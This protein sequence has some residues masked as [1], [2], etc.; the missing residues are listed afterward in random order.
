QSGIPATVFHRDLDDFSCIKLVVYLTDVG[1]DDGPHQFIPYSHRVES[2]NQYLRSTGKKADLPSL[3]R[4]NSKTL[5]SAELQELFN[6]DIVTLTGPAGFG[7]LEDPY[8]L[9]R[10]SRPRATTRLVFSCMYTGLAL[11]FADKNIRNQTGRTVS[12]SEVGLDN[13]S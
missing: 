12:F 10:E 11:P 1:A 5:A 8:G 4:G 9:H 2:L 7:F 13:P 3:F 6:E